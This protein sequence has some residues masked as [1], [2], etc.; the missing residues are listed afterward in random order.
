[1]L[2]YVAVDNATTVSVIDFRRQSMVLQWHALGGTW[3]ACDTPPA[4]VHGIAL[5]HATGPN[6]FPRNLSYT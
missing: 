2:E 4:L 5:I 6:T 1:V 3:T